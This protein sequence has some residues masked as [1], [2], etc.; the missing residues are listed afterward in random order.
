MHSVLLENYHNESGQII[1]KGSN[2][3]IDNGF[4]EAGNGIT[5]YPITC[6]APSITQSQY[7]IDI[8]DTTFIYGDPTHRNAWSAEVNLQTHYKLTTRNA[9]RS[10]QPNSAKALQGLRV[11]EAVGSWC[12]PWRL[13][14]FYLSR[15]GAYIKPF[16]DGTYTTKLG[17]T[18]NGISFTSILTDVTI[19]TFVPGTYYYTAQVLLDS[20]TGKNQTSGEKN[21]VV[22]SGQIVALS[23]ALDT[24]STSSRILR[25]YR[26]TAT[27][28]Y[29]NVANIPLITSI[30][31]VDEG[32][33]ISNIAWTPRTAGPVDA[34]ATTTTGN[35][36]VTPLTGAKLI[37]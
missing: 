28:S 11:H 33:Y 12:P 35:Y 37:A 14:S 7:F 3:T 6:E 13:N 26:G 21:A 36:T 31:I 1:I 22:G 18:V 30:H 16:A 29:N 27:G 20:T 4:F 9:Y 32:N 15:Q 19:S 17:A 34:I 2:V 23:T 25:V 10:V 5:G 24:D 8:V